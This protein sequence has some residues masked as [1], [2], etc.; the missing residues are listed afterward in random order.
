M[1]LALEHLDLRKYDLII[2]SESGPAKGIIPPPHAVHVC[3]CHSPMR[4][5]WNMYLDYRSQAGSLSRPALA[6][7][8][9]YLRQ[10]DFRLRLEWICS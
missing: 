9:H 4:Y 2:S 1:P 6:V 7:F 3:Y 5:I 8:A 10:W